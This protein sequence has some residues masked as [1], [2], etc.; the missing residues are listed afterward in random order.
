LGFVRREFGVLVDIEVEGVRVGVD[1]RNFGGT[2]RAGGGC[3]K[4]QRGDQGEPWAGR[5][6]KCI[7]KSAFNF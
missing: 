2:L 5:S 4:K 6:T 3:D 7:A 1:A